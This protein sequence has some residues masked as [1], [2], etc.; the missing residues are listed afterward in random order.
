MLIS[1]KKHKTGTITLTLLQTSVANIGLSALAALD[2]ATGAGVGPFLMK[3]LSGTTILA[4][5]TCWVAK[6]ADVER[7]REMSTTEW[8]IHTDNLIMAVGGIL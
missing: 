7:A 6:F 8:V 5:E 1:I 4:A 3:D 2:E